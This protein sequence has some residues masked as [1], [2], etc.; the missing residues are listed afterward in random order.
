MLTFLY[1]ESLV[2]TMRL[3][4]ATVKIPRVI[5]R[6]NVVVVISVNV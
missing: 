5:W 3:H 1:D 2:N 4:A 6:L